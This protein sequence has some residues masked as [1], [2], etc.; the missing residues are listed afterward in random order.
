MRYALIFILFVSLLEA[1]QFKTTVGLE[2]IHI[3]QQYR[4]IDIDTNM[5]T[6][7]ARAIVGLSFSPVFSGGNL[8]LSNNFGCG[9]KTIKDDLYA[10]INRNFKNFMITTKLN[11]S[12]AIY[13]VDKPGYYDYAIGNLALNLSR[14]YKKLSAMI[15]AHTGGKTNEITD[16]DYYEWGLGSSLNYNLNLTNRIR[17]YLSFDRRDYRG[18]FYKSYMRMYPGLSL[19]L[20]WGERSQAN[21]G[22]WYD[23]RAVD[24]P[25]E[26][27][28]NNTFTIQH[29]LSA[30]LGKDFFF[31][32]NGNLDFRTYKVQDFVHYNYRELSLLSGIKYDNFTLSLSFAP[33]L[34]YFNAD[35]LYFAEPYYEFGFQAAFGIMKLKKVWFDITNE[36]GKR[37]YFNKTEFSFSTPYTYYNIT[38]NGK[39]WI[40]KNITFNLFGNYSPEWHTNASENL[41]LTYISGNIK[42]E[43]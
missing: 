1:Q 17:F 28:S 30:H 8:S 25:Y 16:Y 27:E 29:D 15:S 32:T 39:L 35:T 21:F 38:L 13:T 34:N 40:A 24:K 18:N 20:L 19:E 33:S 37:T 36:I 5:Y 43:F 6:S 2:T 26:A 22:V 14:N 41:V 7:E 42:Y 4:V 11:F 9:T 31:I 3:F 23:A 12:G 10:T